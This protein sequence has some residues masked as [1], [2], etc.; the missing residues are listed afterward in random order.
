MYISE[1]NKEIYLNDI[2]KYKNWLYT[3]EDYDSFFEKESNKFKDWS[4]K[5]ETNERIIKISDL[6]GSINIIK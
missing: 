3:P 5:L 1:L 2:D 4:L 6:K